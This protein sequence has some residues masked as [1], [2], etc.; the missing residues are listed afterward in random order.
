MPAVEREERMPETVVVI[1]GGMAGLWSALTLGKAGHSV[2]LLERDPPPPAGDVDTAFNEWERKGVGHLRHSHAFL[3]RLYQIIRDHFPELLDELYEAGARELKFA[4]GLPITLKDKYEPLPS[5]ADLS[6]LTCRRTT[7]EFVMRAH[8]E[9]MANVEFI[10]EVIVRGLEAEK[11]PEGLTITGVRGERADGTAETWNADIVV[12]A[13]GK[14]G[15]TDV[16]LKEYGVEYEEFSQ[17]CGILYFTRHYKLRDGWEEPERGV[18]PGAGDL[19]FLKYGVFPGDNRCFSITLSVAEVEMELRKK[20]LHPEVFDGVCAQ[21]PGIAEWTSAERSEPT[22]RVFGMGNLVARW[23]KL[24]DETGKPKVLNYFP[25]GD[26]YVR[27]NPLYGRGC[28]FAAVA[29]Q[30]L[31]TALEE[32]S[33]PVAR[34]KAYIAGTEAE[35]RPYFDNMCKQDLTARKVAEN[36][37]T[38]GYKPSLKSRI[39]KSFLDDG[40]SIALRGD[41]RMMRE[42]MQGFHMLQ[43]P[44]LW[45]KK[46][47][48]AATVA[49]YWVTPKPFKAKLYPPKLGPDRAE[50]LQ[51]V[52][53]SPTADLRQASAAE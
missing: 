14:S 13:S 12:D 10:T 6:I 43:A 16:W 3:A 52:G 17:E 35:L 9:K 42:A 39:A 19:G 23:R 2:K 8:A 51:R 20:I 29:A 53:V 24:E 22:S 37:L 40:I 18:I 30:V 41:V 26:T 25:A 47:G 15:Q 50:L 38:P 31:K 48:N 34:G 27:T 28:S 33:D 32:S 5:D 11:K 21:L 4:D 44:D 45:L 49:R 46:V 36:T 7:L 1:G